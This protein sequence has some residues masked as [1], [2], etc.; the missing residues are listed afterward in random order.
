VR[1]ARHARNMKNTYS[2]PFHILP[3]THIHGIQE[4]LFVLVGGRHRRR[5]LRQDEQHQRQRDRA[6]CWQH[7]LESESRND[8]ASA[9]RKTTALYPENPEVTS[10]RLYALRSWAKRQRGWFDRDD[11]HVRCLKDTWRSNRE[12]FD[13]RVMAADGSSNH[14]K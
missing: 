3:H 9:W 4:S 7:R 10:N 2:R 1:V 11:G 12:Q 5:P 8:E 13:D 6:S 14:S